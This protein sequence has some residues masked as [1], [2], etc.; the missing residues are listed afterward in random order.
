MK[1]LVIGTN[2]FTLPPKGYSGWGETEAYGN[3]TPIQ[4]KGGF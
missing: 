1:I 4:K 3:T 2:V